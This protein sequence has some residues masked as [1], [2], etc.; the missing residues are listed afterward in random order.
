MMLPV[1]QIYVVFVFG[2]GFPEW[3]HLCKVVNEVVAFALGIGVVSGYVVLTY[4]ISD[5]SA[6]FLK[7]RC[8]CHNL[9]HKNSLRAL[10]SHNISP[11]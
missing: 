3:T 11:C 1:S 2:N 5:N 9:V 4:S 7:I 8:N 10:V 6:A